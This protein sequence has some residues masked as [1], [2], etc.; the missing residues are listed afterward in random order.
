MRVRVVFKWPCVVSVMY[1]V[2]LYGVL[3]VVCL[4]WR[5]LISMW[6]I[7]D[8]MRVVVWFVFV[9]VCCVLVFVV[10]CFNVCVTCWRIIARSCIACVLH[11]MCVCWRVCLNVFGCAV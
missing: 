7:C 1:Y 6:L 2:M 4:L 5:V 9:C 10:I 3:G 11:V 8:S